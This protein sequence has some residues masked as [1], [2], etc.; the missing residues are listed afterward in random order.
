MTLMK[1]AQPLALC[2]ILV[3]LCASFAAGQTCPPSLLGSASAYNVFLLGSSSA[4]GYTFDLT[5]GDVEGNVAANGNFRGVSIGIGSRLG[6][7][8]ASTPT[9]I[10]GGYTFFPASW[11]YAVF[12]FSNSQFLFHFFCVERARL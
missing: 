6:S 12:S 8:A 9:V 11:N 5:N 10:I 7:C 3:G 1:S 2:V 4:S